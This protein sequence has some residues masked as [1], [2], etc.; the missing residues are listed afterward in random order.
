MK[1]KIIILGSILFSNF[2][3]ADEAGNSFWFCGQFA[4]LVAVP[5]TVGWNIDSKLYY[6]NQKDTNFNQSSNNSPA[7][8]NITSKTTYFFLEPTY[9][10]NSSWLGGQPSFTISQGFAY[11]FSKATYD[12]S[13]LSETSTQNNW[14]AS[15]MYPFGEIAWNQE[16]HNW[17]VYIMGALP[18]GNFNPNSIFNFGT[19]HYAVD[20][21]FGY[22]YLNKESGWEG[23][24]I[25]GVTYNFINPQTDYKNGLD[26]HLDYAISNFI[27]ADWEL[28]M[29]GYVYYQLTNDSGGDLGPFKS[30]AA[31]IGPQGT[32]FWKSGKNEM[33]FTLRGYW[34]FWTENRLGGFSMYAVYTIQFPQ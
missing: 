7:T 26:S 12:Y 14:G 5:K 22:T 13:G 21:G 17:L 15:N 1:F 27:S 10:P 19:G 23:S 18:V 33:N 11:D 2:L 24:G 29:V 8:A 31:A 30:K 25:F 4:S 16:N 20:L 6:I 3:L 34:D 9:T 28:G 32:Y